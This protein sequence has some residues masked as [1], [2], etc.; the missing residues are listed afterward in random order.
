MAMTYVEQ[1]A[2]SAG[3]SGCR[4][5]RPEAAATVPGSWHSPLVPM[6]RAIGGRVVQEAVFPAREDQLARVRQIVRTAAGGHHEC[7]LI[8]LFANELAANAILHSGSRLIGVIVAHT[9]GGGLRVA[10]YDQHRTGFPHPHERACGRGDI[11]D[12]REHG[13]GLQMIETL[14]DRWGIVREPG[15]GLVTWFEVA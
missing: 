13:R 5:S 2:L 6:A 7:D 4:P 3:T 10:V 11:E 9:A 12:E 8:V 14:A 15:L 1:T